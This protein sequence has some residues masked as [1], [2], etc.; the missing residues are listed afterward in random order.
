MVPG[1]AW[2]SSRFSIR[3]IQNVHIVDVKVLLH[4]GLPIAALQRFRPPTPGL[5]TKSST[6]IRVR[7]LFCCETFRS[8]PSFPTFAVIYKTL[9]SCFRVE[10]LAFCIHP[11]L[12]VFGAPSA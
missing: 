2:Q 3:K 7:N 12:P 9:F 6:V 4:D 10:W 5:V 1:A 11:N 8:Q